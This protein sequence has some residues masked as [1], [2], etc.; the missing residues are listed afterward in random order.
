MNEMS[1]NLSGRNTRTSAAA[2]AVDTPIT[3]NDTQLQGRSRDRESESESLDTPLDTPEPLSQASGGTPP[4]YESLQREVKE[5]RRMREEMRARNIAEAEVKKSGNTV[6]AG[7]RRPDY[8]G[9]DAVN[10]TAI[11]RFAN[12]WF[13]QVKFVGDDLS[14]WSTDPRSLSQRIMK[15]VTVPFEFNE[16]HYYKTKCCKMFLGKFRTIKTN[17]STV[18][19]ETFFGKT[20]HVSEKYCW[21]IS[22]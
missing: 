19:R 11:N 15:D 16:E 13:E 18:A 9:M 3:A 21:L 5:L 4:D 6:R 14:T 2:S 12:Q 17:F 10:Y 22:F 20:N 1:M 8:G 7:G